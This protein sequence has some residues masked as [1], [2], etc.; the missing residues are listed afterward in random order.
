MS[1]DKSFD[2]TN[3]TN[4]SNDKQGKIKDFVKLANQ[5][6]KELGI[7]APPTNEVNSATPKNNAGEG[8]NKFRKLIDNVEWTARLTG[9]NF[10][11]G[12]PVFGKDHIALKE[13]AED[14]LQIK[15]QGNMETTCQM[16]QKNALPVFLKPVGPLLELRISYEILK[17]M[18]ER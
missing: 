5:K 2:S 9:E 4:K 10:G 14:T 16:K 11:H 12:L 17:G 13:K 6:R 1:G 7:S 18:I 8:S 15:Y 3:K